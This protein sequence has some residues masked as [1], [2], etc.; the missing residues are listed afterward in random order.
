MYI[1]DILGRA[2]VSE[3]QRSCAVNLRA[4]GHLRSA[5]LLQSNFDVHV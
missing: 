3:S 1:Q 5:A 2:M 4:P